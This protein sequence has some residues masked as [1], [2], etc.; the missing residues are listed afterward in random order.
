MIR[1]FYVHMPKLPRIV[2]SLTRGSIAEREDAI[3]NLPWVQTEKDKALTKCRRSQ[4][5]WCA[6]KP[7]MTLHT[8]TNEEG[9]PLDDAD[10]SAARLCSCAA[11]N[12]EAKEGHH[13]DRSCE[14]I[15]NHVERALDD[16]Q[17]TLCKEGFDEML[18]TKKESAPSPD[19]SRFL[20]STDVLAVVARFSLMLEGSCKEM[21][22]PRPL[23]PAEL[24]SYQSL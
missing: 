4:R 2:A 1:P 3:S 19:G 16:I 21:A 17:W 15:L 12:F 8:V 9:Q 20:V 10:E 7:Q 14:T 18:V 5:A 13:Q 22:A 6:K 11:D 24:S 23:P